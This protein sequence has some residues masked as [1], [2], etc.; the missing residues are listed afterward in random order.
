MIVCARKRGINRADT[1]LPT[2]PT[3]SRAIPAMKAGVN[4][5]ATVAAS[6]GAPVAVSRSPVPLASAAAADFLA[7]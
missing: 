3:T 5:A 2:K 7:P 4:A 1:T 6:D